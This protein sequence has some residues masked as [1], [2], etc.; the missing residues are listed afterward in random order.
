MCYIQLSLLGCPGYVVIDDSL[1]RPSVSYDARGLLPK[2]GPQVWYTPMYFRDVWHYRRIGA[3]MDLLFRNAAEQVPAEPPA[4][5][6]PPEQS[7]PLAETKTG[8]LTLFLMGGNGMRRPP[9][10]GE[11]DMEARGRRLFDGKVGGRFLFRPSQRK[12]NRTTNAVK[13]RAQRLGLGAVLMAGEYVTLNQLLLAVNGGSGSYGYKMKSWVEN[14]G[15]PVHTKKVNR[16][17]FRVV[18]I[19]EFWEW[20]ERYRSLHRLFPKWSRWRSA[21]SRAG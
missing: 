9:P 12:L 6:A 3:Q 7:Q 4:P 15:L 11:P 21:R 17:S 5:A 10:L 16:C 20:A 19:E 8:Q 1:L 14:R 2:D 13:V 18:Y